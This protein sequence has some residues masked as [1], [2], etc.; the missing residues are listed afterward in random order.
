MIESNFDPAHILDNVGASVADIYI[1]FNHEKAT[2]GEKGFYCFVEGY[3]SVYY[4]PRIHENCVFIP[5]KGKKHVIQFH[6]FWFGRPESHRYKSGFFID[7]DFE[8]NPSYPDSIFVTG[9]YSIENYYSDWR[10]FACILEDI[11]YVKGVG[12][13]QT[14]HDQIISEYKAEQVCYHNHTLELNAWYAVLKES[15]GSGEYGSLPK[16]DDVLKAEVCCEIGNI[17]HQYTLDSLNAVYGIA[18]KEVDPDRLEEKKRYLREDPDCLLRG[19][20]EAYFLRM[21]LESL[22][23]RDL[24]IK[25]MK[26]VNI[27]KDTYLA[28]FSSCA[29]NMPELDEYIQKRKTC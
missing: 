14:V 1:R 3:D 15:C 4:R 12:S 7:R 23:R 20:S 9:R 26:S 27:D 21:F 19:K 10:C 25:K 11:Y 2:H 5:C 24:P 28:M 13:T 17:S 18:G 6:G 16:F 22:K 29:L 8:I